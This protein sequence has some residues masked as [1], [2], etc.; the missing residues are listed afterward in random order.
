Y[1]AVPGG[2]PE[3]LPNKDIASRIEMGDATH[4]NQ[5]GPSWYPREGGYRWMPKRAS[6]ILRGPGEPGEKLYLKGY[7]PA[8]ALQADAL[9][10]EVSVDGEKLPAEWVRK[11]DAEFSFSF[12]L[13]AEATGKAK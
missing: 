1:G 10:V 9:A 3:N 2:P 6:V 8:A 12:P 4:A 5:L 13:P 7:C 11:R